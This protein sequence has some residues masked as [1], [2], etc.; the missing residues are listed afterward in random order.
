MK[1]AWVLLISL[2]FSMS[3][4]A[5]S[6]NAKKDK[7]QTVVF[8]PSDRQVITQYF[9]GNTS[10]LP[11]GLAKRG[12]NLPPGLQKHVRETGHLP[13]GLDKRVEPFPYDLERRL[14]VL[15]PPY[16]RGIIGDRGVIYD[17][18]GMGILDMIDLLTGARLR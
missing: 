9:R 3:I 13:P 2:I 18:R 7:G 1:N 10:N 5:P 6:V 12:R 8:G 4:F 14:P 11:P 16:R 17:P 15:Q